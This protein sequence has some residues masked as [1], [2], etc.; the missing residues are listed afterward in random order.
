MLIML[1]EISKGSHVY[2]VHTMSATIMARHLKDGNG[3]Y[4]QITF[5]KYEQYYPRILGVNARNTPFH[6]FYL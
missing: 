6:I 2:C 1:I 4:L 3:S 5:M